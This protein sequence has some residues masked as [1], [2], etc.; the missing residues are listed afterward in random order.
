[1]SPGLPHRSAQSEFH[2]LQSRV[3][4]AYATVPI[5]S[6]FFI[7]KNIV[8]SSANSRIY[9]PIPQLFHAI[10]RLKSGNRPVGRVCRIRPDTGD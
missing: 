9:A 10:S 3:S 4:F 7:L 8:D 6:E 1:L 5:L 2:P